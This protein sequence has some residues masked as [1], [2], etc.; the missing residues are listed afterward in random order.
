LLTLTEVCVRR[1]QNNGEPS[2]MH[3]YRSFVE[4]SLA[5]MQ[6]VSRLRRLAG[7]TEEEVS[8]VGGAE[9][10]EEMPRNFGG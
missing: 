1:R 9:Q 7:C 3:G 8:A 4:V 2:S 5:E 10:E 6:M